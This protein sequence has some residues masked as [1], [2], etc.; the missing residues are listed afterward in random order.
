VKALGLVFSARKRGN[1]LNAVEYVLEKLNEQNFQSEIVN[2]YDYEIKPCSKCNY[3]CFSQYLRGTEEGCPIHDDVPEIYEKMKQADILIFAVPTYGGNVSGLYK[4]F[5]ERA[6]GIFKE[7]EN[8]VDV[9]LSKVI[10]LIVIGNVPA[11]GE[12][13]YHSAIMDYYDA[14]YFTAILLQSAEY[15]KASIKGDLIENQE[16]KMRLDNLV[17]NILKLWNK[18]RED[19]KA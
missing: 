15:G 17:N 4:A 1:C 16:I 18:K 11:G 13:A 5:Q 3:E 12:L 2:A 7:Y 10:G 6:Q 8:F 9:I 19:G 14:K